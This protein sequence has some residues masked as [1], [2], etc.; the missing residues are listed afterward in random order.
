MPLERLNASVPECGTLVRQKMSTVNSHFVD[1]SG[2]FDDAIQLLSASNLVVTQQVAMKYV[3][4]EIVAK[5]QIYCG[6]FIPN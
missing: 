2:D 6:T 5:R 3:M 4:P 1:G